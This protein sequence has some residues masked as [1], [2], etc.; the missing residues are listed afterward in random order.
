MTI[1]Q[2]IE[3]RDDRRIY[4]ELPQGIPTGKVIIS[5][6]P[7]KADKKN[8]SEAEEIEIINRNAQRLNLEAM[9]VFSYQ[10]LDL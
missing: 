4:F 6:T 9:D 1:T 5:F 10:N 3:V 2:T 7:V 8:M